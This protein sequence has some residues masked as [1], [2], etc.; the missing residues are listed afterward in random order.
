MDIIKE[1]SRKLVTEYE[2][3]FH[4][5]TDSGSGYGFPC[6]RNG[7]LIESQMQEAGLA[8]YARCVGGLLD[9]V[10]DGVQ[11]WTYTSY[12]PAIGLCQCGRKVE[13]ADAWLN[14]CGCG[15]DYNGSGQLLAPRSQWGEETN[16]TLSDMLN[17]QED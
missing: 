10:Y 2:H 15:R 4:N 12:D 7:K 1:A 5:R 6:D 8:N 9:V 14:V 13:L 3:R 17:G 16:E 11:S